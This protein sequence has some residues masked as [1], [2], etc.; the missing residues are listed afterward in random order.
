MNMKENRE[1]GTM[2]LFEATIVFPIVF[3]I[4]FVMLMMGNVYFMHSAMERGIVQTGINA[5]ASSENPMMAKI[6]ETGQIPTSPSNGPDVMPYRYI[7]TGNVKSICA[8]ME[9]R[10]T[11]YAG[12]LKSIALFRGIQPVINSVDVTPNMYLIYSEVEVNCDF[13]ITLPL[14]ML[15]ED[16]RI[17]FRYKL[18]VK[19]P[20]GDPAEFVRNAAMVKDY[21]ERSEAFMNFAHQISDKMS[22][23]ANYIN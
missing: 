21:M 4:V 2:T 8:D 10:L 18:S 20:I 11:N 12:S 5:A 3:I 22:K 14:R 9:S 15:F 19:E 16:E 23:I 1:K 7:F 13:K 17:G 6:L